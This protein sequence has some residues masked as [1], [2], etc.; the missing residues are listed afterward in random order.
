MRRAKAPQEPS[1]PGQAPSAGTADLPTCH[2]TG[3][4]ELGRSV[5][6]TGAWGFPPCSRRA[7]PH[8]CRGSSERRAG[9]EDAGQPPG[10]T[11][12]L[13]QES[14]Q[15]PLPQQ[16]LSVALLAQ[17]YFFLLGISSLL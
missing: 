15:Q 3:V 9:S 5:L 2:G 14:K 8:C 16:A 10:S 1:R 4:V 12:G 7:H 6:P 11:G 17:S 13:Q